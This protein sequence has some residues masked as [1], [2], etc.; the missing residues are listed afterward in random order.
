MLSILKSKSSS[1]EVTVSTRTIVRVLV[2]I[3]ASILFVT[4]VRRASHPLTLIFVA[5]FLALA[6]NAP[7]HWIA[8]HL[9]GKRKG[10][11]TVAT[12]VSFLVVIA[13][14]AAFIASLVPP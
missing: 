10:N 7:V 4:A 12:G 2:L 8:S 6:L 14:L 11:R 13:L 5:F 3:I 1:I 9:P